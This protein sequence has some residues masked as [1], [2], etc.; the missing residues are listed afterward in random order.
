MWMVLGVL[1]AITTM[2]SW[3][4]RPNHMPTIWALCSP[5]SD[6]R[7]RNGVSLFVASV[8][9]PFNCLFWRTAVFV[10]FHFKLVGRAS[11]APS[12]EPSRQIQ[13]LH[14]RSLCTIAFLF[15][16]SY[17]WMSIVLFYGIQY[18]C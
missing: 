15:G 16:V 9:I 3:L 11:P 13:E 17:A 5:R 6:F 14:W 1:P 2:H 12:L 8:L 18:D 4:W 10:P 7:R